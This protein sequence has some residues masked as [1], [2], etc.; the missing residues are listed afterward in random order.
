[1]EVTGYGRSELSNLSGQTDMPVTYKL[2]RPLYDLFAAV[3]V[4]SIPPAIV[5]TI[6]GHGLDDA[7]IIGTPIECF[8][9][10]LAI[11]Q[12]EATYSGYPLGGIRFTWQPAQIDYCKSHVERRVIELTV[13]D[14]PTEVVNVE[15]LPFDIVK[16]GTR[17]VLDAL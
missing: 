8:A 12:S 6:D 2:T 15:Q 1:M 11:R 7:R 17:S 16:N 14:G 4:R 3:D 9:T 10:F 13:Y 5:F